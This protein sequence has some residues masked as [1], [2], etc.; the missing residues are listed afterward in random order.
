[1]MLDVIT[2]PGRIIVSQWQSQSQSQNHYQPHWPGT[3]LKLASIALPSAGLCSRS[4]V[5]EQSFVPNQSVMESMVIATRVPLGDWW[6]SRMV[7]QIR[8]LAITNIQPSPA[9]STAVTSHA[10]QVG[11]FLTVDFGMQR[12]LMVRSS[13]LT[14]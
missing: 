11:T 13:S 7:G 2:G 12:R 10:E 8:P 3:R 6:S 9:T 14:L 4:Q 1:M 5:V